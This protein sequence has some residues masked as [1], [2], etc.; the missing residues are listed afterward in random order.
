MRFFDRSSFAGLNV[1]VHVSKDEE[2]PRGPSAEALQCVIHI[3]TRFG[4]N[5]LRC[6][7]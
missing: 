5:R 2:L 3:L 7:A 6:K 1:S 4:I